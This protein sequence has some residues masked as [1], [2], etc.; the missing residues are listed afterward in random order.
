MIN[1]TSAAYQ[2]L[3]E[4]SLS[5]LLDVHERILPFINRT[6]VMT[7]SYIDKLVDSSLF[8][9]CENFQKSGCFQ[10]ERC[11]ECSLAV[12]RCSIA[13]GFTTHSSGNHAQA[14]ALSAKMQGVPS[15]I[16]MPQ[17][18]PIIKRNATAGYGAKIIQSGNRIQD[19][20]QTLDG[21]LAETEA[22]FIHP[23]NDVH[24]IKGQATVALELM[25]EVDHLDCIVAPRWRWWT[26]SGT[27][28]AAKCSGN[29]IK[30]YGAEPKQVDD[31]Y[32]SLQKGTIQSNDHV[33]TI[34]DGLRTQLV[35]S[36]LPSL[37]SM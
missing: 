19:R 36:H 37:E 15:Y 5:S 1:A 32:R 23:Y 25:Q 16:V 26:L 10:N 7:S 28:L 2:D 18:A 4:T 29:S 20:E 22:T 35:L 24:V 11:H 3:K 34:A 9:K 13:N 30:V 31:A 6:P 21:V 27:L 14:V 12:E 33:N 17:N 8:F